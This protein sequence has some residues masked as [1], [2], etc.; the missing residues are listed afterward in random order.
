MSSLRADASREEI[1]EEIDFLG[2]LV[3]SLDEYA[4]DAAEKKTEFDAQLEDLHH[5]LEALNRPAGGAR[6]RTPELDIGTGNIDGVNLPSRERRQSSTIDQFS[7]WN[8]TRG[9]A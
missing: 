5:R 2:A 6:P 3:E 7:E 1:E 8:C 4:E 9:S